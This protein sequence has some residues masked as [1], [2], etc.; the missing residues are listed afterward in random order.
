MIIAAAVLVGGGAVAIAAWGFTA[1]IELAS[2][3]GQEDVR[4]PT[5]TASADPP[6]EQHQTP[7]LPP[8][9]ELRR[10][11][12]LDLRRPLYDEPTEASDGNDPPPKPE[13]PL[14]VKLIGTAVEEGKSEA[15]LQMTDGSIE[16]VGVG[17][18][19]KDGD[20]VLRVTRIEPGKVAV[21]YRGRSH[22][23]IGPKPENGAARP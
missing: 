15:I 5:T 10:L 1:P 13:K 7:S 20:E 22:E 14:R 19:V 23:L 6:A 9:A 4:R 21:E 8:L 11:W 17:Q 18:S 3:A 2:E 12:V 16:I